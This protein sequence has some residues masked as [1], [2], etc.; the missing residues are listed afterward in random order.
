MIFT[1]GL[2]YFH[3]SHELWVMEFASQVARDWEKKKKGEWSPFLSFRSVRNLA[4]IYDEK[5]VGLVYKIHSKIA[6]P[7]SNQIAWFA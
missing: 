2:W 7:H 5:A 1:D 6:T 4:G 3:S